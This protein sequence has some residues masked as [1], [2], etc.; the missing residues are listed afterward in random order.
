[1]APTVVSCR[2]TST[3]KKSLRYLDVG[4]HCEPPT[5]FE[6]CCSCHAELSDEPAYLLMIS[7]TDTA[8]RGRRDR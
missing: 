2:S 5:S 8:H 3:C 1:M 4:D 6:L 7:E